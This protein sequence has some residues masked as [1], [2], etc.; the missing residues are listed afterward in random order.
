[1]KTDHSP[2]SITDEVKSHNGKYSLSKAEQDLYH[3]EDDVV[4]KIIQVKRFDLPNNGER[5]KILEDSNP[6]IVLEG[7]KLSVTE[8]NFLKTSEGLNFIISSYKKGAKTLALLRDEL[9]NKCAKS[10]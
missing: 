7:I 9:K 4:C 8:K 6:V 3:E 5:W 1:M 2:N 10:K